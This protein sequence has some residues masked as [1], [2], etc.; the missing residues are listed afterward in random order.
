M[1]SIKGTHYEKYPLLAFTPSGMLD[2]GYGTAI[3]MWMDW[4]Y[5][6]LRSS[7]PIVMGKSMGDFVPTSHKN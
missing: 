6:C 3:T 1:F 4:W 7:T 5:L 2:I